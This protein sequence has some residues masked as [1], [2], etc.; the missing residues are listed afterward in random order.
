MHVN[1]PKVE[2]PIVKAEREFFAIIK[3]VPQ[4]SQ[5]SKR[6]HNYHNYQKGATDTNAL[7]HGNGVDGNHDNDYDV[8]VNDYDNNGDDNED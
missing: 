3:K 1:N 2:D 6:F 8:P 7:H 4:L 5:L